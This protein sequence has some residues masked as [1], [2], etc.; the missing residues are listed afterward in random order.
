MKASRKKDGIRYGNSC[1]ST[2]ISE[3]R[4]GAILIKVIRVAIGQTETMA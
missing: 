1:T 4:N 2:R 3:V